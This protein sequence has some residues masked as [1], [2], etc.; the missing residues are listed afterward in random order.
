MTLQTQIEEA[1]TDAFR[2][3]KKADVAV[4]RLLKSALKNE[5]IALRA[6]SLTD[7]QSLAVI[8]RE[9][10]RRRDSIQL[11]TQGNRP[12]LAA[13]EEAELAYLQRFL[14]AEL[15][16]SELETL[17]QGAIAESGAA[18]P[19]EMGKVMGLLKPKISGRADGGRVAALTKRLL[20]G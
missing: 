6:T 11:Y 1:Y 16:D 9:V 2:L 10:K 14:P 3:G 19:S 8:R 18:G 4:L 7:E 15:T 17:V 5:E 13:T 20:G 12:E